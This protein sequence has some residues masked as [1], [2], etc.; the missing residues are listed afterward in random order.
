MDPSPMDIQLCLFPLDTISISNTYEPTVSYVY[1]KK[2]TINDEEEVVVPD[3]DHHNKEKDFS[4]LE[5]QFDEAALRNQGQQL[6][7]CLLQNIQDS[8]SIDLDTA[9]SI[10]QELNF[11]LDTTPVEN[12]NNQASNEFETL[13][14]PSSSSVTMIKYSSTPVDQ[15]TSIAG[16]DRSYTKYGDLD[17]QTIAKICQFN[18][19]APPASCRR[20]PIRLNRKSLAIISWTNISKD[21]VMNH[22]KQE[23]SIKNI[24]YI[25]VGE[26]ISEIDGQKHLDIQ[27][28]FKGKVNKKT[29]FLDPICQT[30]CNYKVT[31]DTLAWNDYI[32]NDINCLEFGQFKSKTRGSKQRPSSSTITTTEAATKVAAKAATKVAAKAA[33]KAAAGQ[34]V[35]S[36]ASIPLD[37][38]QS[39][40]RRTKTTIGTQTEKRRKHNNEKNKYAPQLAQTNMVLN[41]EPIDNI[42]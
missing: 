20:Q 21:V 5:E 15:T 19:Q 34:A 14:S 29:R 37:Q 8:Q 11:I 7:E 3:D 10:I 22:I 28:I 4:T 24:Q 38:D 35:A 18:L 1:K 16:R 13:L 32:K 31:Q 30:C 27:I 33:A 6:M 41:D 39:L 12:T 23:F 2:Q 9:N 42:H 25:C 36:C 40:V 26:G 17:R